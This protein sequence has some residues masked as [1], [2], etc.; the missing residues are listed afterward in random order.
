MTKEI[1]VPAERVWGMVSDLPRMGEWSPENEGATWL[2][3]ATG[4][5]PG[6]AFRGRNRNGKK[7]WTTEGVVVD[8]D[9]GRLFTF[10]TS[11]AGFKIAEWRYEFETT[12]SG[13]LVTETWIDQRG[14]VVKAM[15]KPVSGVADRATHNKRTMEETLER[16]KKAAESG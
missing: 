15:G 12:P 14:R 9:P 11:V 16:L 10:R 3:G 13:C 4:P 1:N 7:T 6:T 5:E 8:A 2:R